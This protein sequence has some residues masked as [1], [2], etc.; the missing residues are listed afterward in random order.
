MTRADDTR[1]TVTFNG[2]DV[3][4]DRSAIR[5]GCS[6]L[7]K[8]VLYRSTDPLKQHVVVRWKRGLPKRRDEPWYLMTD[9][10]TVSER[11][12]ARRLS[13]LYGRRMSIEQLFRD[14]KN[15]RDGWSLRDT[16]LTRPERLDR[17]IL[18]LAL[19]YL[20]LVGVGLGLVATRRHRP[21]A[22]SSNN[23]ADAASL[24]Q[25][26]RWMLAEHG[27]IGALPAVRRQ[28]AAEVPKWG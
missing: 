10:P 7:R 6:E 26:G 15:K 9:L 11:W 2:Q 16:G 23:R 8:S 1:S 3:R 5:R 13:D 12:T 22:W 27:L 21:G 19:A 24:F 25:I 28:L 14:G 4:P 18:V 17:L 20:L